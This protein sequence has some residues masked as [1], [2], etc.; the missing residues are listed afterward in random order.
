MRYVW[1][2][3]NKRPPLPKDLPT[4]QR[5]AADM[6]I[7]LL[8]ILM[9]V[10]PLSGFLMSYLGGHDVSVYGLFTIPGLKPKNP[11]GGFFHDL[12]GLAGFI[13]ST[14]VSAH[15]A[16]GLFHHYVRKDNVLKRMLRG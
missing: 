8:Y 9:F 5:K 3:M 13:L 6:N 14:S 16:G 15:I 7:N 2:T 11:A 4:W 1:S 10:M 12:H